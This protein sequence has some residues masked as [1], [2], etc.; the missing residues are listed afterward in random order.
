MRVYTVHV[1]R[2]RRD[3]DRNVVLVKEG[4][5]WPAFFFSAI[6]AIWKGLWLVAVL[7]VVLEIALG[8]VFDVFLIDPL[9]QAALALLLSLAIGFFA[10]DLRRWTLTRRG[11]RDGGVVVGRNLLA[12][13]RRLF[14]GD[15]GLAADLLS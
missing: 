12:A 9:T 2:R 11:F 14:E 15:P 1:H 8:L 6:W 5:C 10:N 3:P 7:F 13:E 4:F